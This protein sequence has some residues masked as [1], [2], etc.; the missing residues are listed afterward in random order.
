MRW[1]TVIAVCASIASTALA[2]EGSGVQP[3]A[4][5]A[6]EG[7]FRPA[8]DPALTRFPT[9]DETLASQRAVQQPAPA[10]EQALARAREAAER[11]LDRSRQEHAQ[12]QSTAPVARPMIVS[13]LDGTA[14]IVSTLDGTAPIISPLGR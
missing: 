1:G 3:P 2:Q 11:E 12:A 6:Q 14:P 8:R 5:A 7:F 10:D 13:P 4:P 9:P